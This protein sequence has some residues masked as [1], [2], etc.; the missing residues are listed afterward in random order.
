[1]KKSDYSKYNKDTIR[2]LLYNTEHGALDKLAHSYHKSV[3]D[4]V[5]DK[6]YSTYSKGLREFYEFILR[7]A[8]QLLRD[9]FHCSKETESLF[10]I[11][12]IKN[13]KEE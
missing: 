11:Y 13:S 10:V 8:L 6:D 9:Y 4:F 2:L 7:T 5:N 1:M 3:S 12:G